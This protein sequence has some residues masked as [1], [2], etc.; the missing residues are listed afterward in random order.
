MSNVT[1]IL[2]LKFGKHAS[3]ADWVTAPSTLRVIQ[4]ES[5]AIL[6]RD[7]RRLERNLYSP[8]NRRFNA[9]IGPQVLDSVAVTQLMRGVAANSDGGAFTVQTSMEQAD[10]LD[11]IFGTAAA[12]I[13]GAAPTVAAAGHTTSTLV[14]VGTTIADG[15]MILFPTSLGAVAREV[16]SGG[17]TTTLT[18]DR[19]YV[20]TPTTG[21]TVVR[22][23]RWNLDPTV[24][25]IV[26]GGFS[27]EGEDWL[28]T[29]LGCACESFD[30]SFAE[31]EIVRM[32]TSWLPTSFAPG[33]DGALSFTAPTFGSEIVAV[34]AGL[35]IGNDK[36]LMQ[37]MAFSMK[38]AL[39]PRT[40]SQGANGQ[41][42]YIR[43]N[44]DD[45]S[46]SAA[47]YMGA[48]SGS[49]GELTYDGTAPA[50]RDLTES[51]TTRDV[52]IQIGLSA[53]AAMY[54]RMPAADVRMSAVENDGIMM[55]QMTCMAT[56]P[57]SGSALRLAIF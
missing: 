34:N 1:R 2:E 25:D 18:L 39:R 24:H 46:L 9:V 22:G 33:V 13:V 28:Q 53:G 14:V 8:D 32:S 56:K 5:A 55:A 26:H 4:P 44:N 10:M 21:G 6:P 3:A 48:D 50:F 12:A 20:G 23:A 16:V 38:N 40:T 27:A 52:A 41:L 47:L 36:R 7:T 17:G 30:L 35:W 42:G 11:V 15:D 45:V 49:I 51:N 43:R 54:L 37:G 29:I 19:T 57:T 31:G